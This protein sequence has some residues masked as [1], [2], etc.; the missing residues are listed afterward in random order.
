MVSLCP[1][2][3]IKQAVMRFVYDIF[4]TM[5]QKAK[6][7]ASLFALRSLTPESRWDLERCDQNKRPNAQFIPPK[8][9]LSGVD[10]LSPTSLLKRYF[11][12]NINALIFPSSWAKKASEKFPDCSIGEVVFT[13]RINFSILLLII[14]T[15]SLFEF[16][17]SFVGRKIQLVCFFCFFLIIFV[18]RQ[19]SPYGECGGKQN[20]ERKAC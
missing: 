10:N 19:M 9:H 12:R 11:D 5:C 7:C 17:A 18:F 8:L 20:L 4:G 14:K 3:L 15:I 16:Y 2:Q 6:V 13:V 1:A